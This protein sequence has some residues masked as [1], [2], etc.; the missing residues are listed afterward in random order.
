MEAIS[1]YNEENFSHS[2]EIGDLKKK[3][4]ELKSQKASLKKKEQ[5]LELVKKPTVETA[6]DAEGFN[7]FNT[8]LL[9]KIQDG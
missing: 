9:Q 1:K 4:N 2:S 6:Y 8:R 5:S 7:P 3:L